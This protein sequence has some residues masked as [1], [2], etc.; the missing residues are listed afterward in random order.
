[1]LRKSP[2]YKFSNHFL[3][4]VL[5]SYQK[6][7]SSWLQEVSCRKNSSFKGAGS[8]RGISHLSK[9]ETGANFCE[10]VKAVQDH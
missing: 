6:G 2:L 8:S 1:M 9:I 4:A 7:N 3:G 5:L 10:K